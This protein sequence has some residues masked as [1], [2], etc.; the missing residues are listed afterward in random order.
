MRRERVVRDLRDISSEIVTDPYFEN[1]V[2]LKVGFS[3]C[4]ALAT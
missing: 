1:A 2:R 4:A 3:A